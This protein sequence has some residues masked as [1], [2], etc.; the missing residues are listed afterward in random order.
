[1][2]E[3]KDHL[4]QDPPLRPEGDADDRPFEVPRSWTDAVTEL[5]LEG[6]QWTPPPVPARVLN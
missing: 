1:M 4:D 6:P 5:Q 2:T 3:K